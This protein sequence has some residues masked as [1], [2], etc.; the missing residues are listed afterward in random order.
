MSKTL[1]YMTLFFLHTCCTFDLL[2]N[3]LFVC[4]RLCSIEWTRLKFICTGCVC[5]CRLFGAAVAQL[6]VSPSFCLFAWCS[7]VILF[8][9]NWSPSKTSHD[10]SMDDVFALVEVSVSLFS[11]SMPAGQTAITTTVDETPKKV[12]L[13]HTLWCANCFISISTRQSKTCINWLSPVVR[14]GASTAWWN[15]VVKW[16]RIV[17]SWV[18]VIQRLTEKV[19]E[20][21]RN[22]SL[23]IVISR[24]KRRQ[25]SVVSRIVC[26][27]DWTTRASGS[28]PSYS[29]TSNEGTSLCDDNNA[30]PVGLVY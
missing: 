4:F 17:Y 22:V 18:S 2:L 19:G 11:R 8:G 29:S 23:K 30:E 1:L 16:I 27:N 7:L 3:R 5:L 26:W 6:F 21:L 15:F 28:G 24:S 10:Q 9:K 14:N 13:F 12:G 25:L 20:R